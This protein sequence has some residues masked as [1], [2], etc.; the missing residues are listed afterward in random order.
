[1]NV[2]STNVPAPLF[3]VSKDPQRLIEREIK[4]KKRELLS[5]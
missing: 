1:V 4:A 3:K 2:V 5:K